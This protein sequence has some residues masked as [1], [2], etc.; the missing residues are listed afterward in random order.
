MDQQSR[1]Q[2]FVREFMCKEGQQTRDLLK[3][4]FQSS[5]DARPTK[6]NVCIFSGSREERIPALT[7]THLYSLQNLQV[8]DVGY[9]QLGEE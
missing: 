3:Q 2:E 1:M 6:K 8:P 7:V 4:L 5:Q 9:S